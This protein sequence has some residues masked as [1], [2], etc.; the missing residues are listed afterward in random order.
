MQALDP[1]RREG[2]YLASYTGSL[3]AAGQAGPG[4]AQ[5]LAGR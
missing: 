1:A 4:P 2:P 3:Q 5:A